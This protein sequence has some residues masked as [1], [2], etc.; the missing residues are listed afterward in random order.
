MSTAC[1]VVLLPASAMI[2]LMA[3]QGHVNKLVRRSP[4]SPPCR[5]P[6]ADSQPP[7]PWAQQAVHATTRHSALLALPGTHTPLPLVIS[8]PATRAAI[9][10]G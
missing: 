4:H 5:Q 3:L 10:Q 9:A 6:A 7:P 8:P 2:V 1:S